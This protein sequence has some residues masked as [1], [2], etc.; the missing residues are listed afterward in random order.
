MFLDE[1]DYM[2][3]DALK[4]VIRPRLDTTPLVFQV[5]DDQSRRTIWKKQEIAEENLNPMMF[6]LPNCEIN[7]WP[8]DAAILQEVKR[9]KGLKWIREGIGIANRRPSVPRNLT[10]SVSSKGSH[11]V[12]DQSS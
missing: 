11:R 4:N 12:V 1:F 2:A 3:P 7:H 5:Y 8:S 9:Q 10:S 6:V